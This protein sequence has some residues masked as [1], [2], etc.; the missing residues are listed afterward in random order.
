MDGQKPPWTVIQ[1]GFLSDYFWAA[2]QQHL[3]A[4]R[5]PFASFLATGPQHVL[6]SPQQVSPFLQQSCTAAQQAAAL[7][8]H[9]MPLAQQ[10]SLAG[11]AQHALSLVQQASFALQQSA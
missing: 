9:F 5:Q 10:P 6:F 8:Q 11:A 2:A 1:G 4:P 7:A 3:P